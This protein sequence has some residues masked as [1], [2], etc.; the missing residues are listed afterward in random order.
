MRRLDNDKAIKLRK[1]GMSYS[2]IKQKLGVSKG[3]LSYWLR[4]YPLPEKRIRELR[5]WNERRIENYRETRRRKREEILRD[6]YEKTEEDLLPFTKRDLM[7]AGWFLYWGEGTKSQIS[8]V[9]ISNTNPAAIIAFMSWLVECFGVDKSK[10]RVRLQLYSDMDIEKESGWWSKML[11][12]PFTQFR[13][14]YIKKSSL[15]AVKYHNSYSH[16]TC[17]VIFGS[18]KLG[19][20]VHMGLKV[21]ENYFNTNAG[22]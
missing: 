15:V 2:Q 5:D 21:L 6:V 16:G 7:I 12:L 14:P 18:A 4:D 13:K 20:I 8:E 19:K 10:L 3:T 11:D 9:S 17:N 22:V 1:Q